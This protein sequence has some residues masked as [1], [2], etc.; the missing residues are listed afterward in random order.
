MSW[1][2]AIDWF[3]RDR[4]FEHQFG[5][6]YNTQWS[7]SNGHPNPVKL[8]AFIVSIGVVVGVFL[9]AAGL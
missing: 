1:D 6:R 2:K 8:V 5:S 7:R 3:Y 9:V 4:G